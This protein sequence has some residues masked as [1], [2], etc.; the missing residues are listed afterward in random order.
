MGE[1][2]KEK[3]NINL[4]GDV[5]PFSVPKSEEIFYVNAREILIDRLAVLK[6][7]YAGLANMNQLLTTLAVEAL[8]DALKVDKRYKMLKTEVN[9]RVENLQ[10]GLSD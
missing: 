8:V 3:V 10:T 7:K 1:E 5:V 9:Q 4:S 2:K 6:N